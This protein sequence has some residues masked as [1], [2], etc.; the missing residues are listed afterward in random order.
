MQ[1]VAWLPVAM[2]RTPAST[3]L[4]NTVRLVICLHMQGVPPVHVL[5]SLSVLRHLRVL[6]V[7]ALQPT[8]VSNTIILPVPVLCYFW[9]LGFPPTSLASRG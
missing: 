4:I 1:V 6:D 7:R 8:G 3:I 2:G 9:R 5:M